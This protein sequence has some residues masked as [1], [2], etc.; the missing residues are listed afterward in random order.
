VG[1][2][3]LGARGLFTLI[4]YW[5][6]RK[7]YH[8]MERAHLKKIEVRG[9][10][11]DIGTSSARYLVVFGAETMLMA[12]YMHSLVFVLPVDPKSAT[13]HWLWASA[14]PIQFLVRQTLSFDFGAEKDFWEYALTKLDA[15]C[16][17]LE[18]HDRQRACPSRR[19]CWVRCCLSLISHH[20]YLNIIFWTLPLQ[21]MVSQTGMDF[22]KDTFAIVFIPSL[23]LYDEV[24]RYKVVAP[25]LSPRV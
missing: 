17:K 15:S 16:M 23:D 13:M 8:L 2:L 5:R 12:Y 20:V 3:I 6:R 14:L 11:Q 9:I 22:V 4:R 21:L 18:R 25:L 24:K 19:E 1:L 7:S 10:Y